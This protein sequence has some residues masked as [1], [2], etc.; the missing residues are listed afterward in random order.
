[1]P[2]FRSAALA[3]S[4]LAVVLPLT[5]CGSSD[6]DTGSAAPKPSGTVS[7]AAQS[8]DLSSVTLRVGQTG[9]AQLPAVLKVAGLDNTPYKVKWSV[10]PGGDKQ[11]QALQAGALDVASSSDI[12]PVFAAAATTPKWKVVGIQR[13]NTLLQNVV[14]GKKSGI[15]TIAQLKGKKVGYVQATTA[16]YFLYKLL[17]AAGLKWTDIHAVPLTP[18]D[19]VAA[20]SSGSIDAL[21]SYGNSIITTQQQGA[22]VIGSGQDILSGN[23]PYE[24]SDQL[25]ADADR[26]AALVDL[27]ARVNKAFTVLRDGHEAD[28]AELTAAATHEPESVA[29]AQI[30][31]DEQQIPSE[32][33]VGGP[34]Q[35]AKEQDVADTFS[36]LGIL[37][38]TVD[39]SSY[40]SDALTARL[41]TALAGS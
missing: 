25:I 11:I 26:S 19:G 36:Q 21:A 22:K 4:L 28:Y 29:L 35:I 5:A 2:R 27:L 34:D 40:W 41:T 15:T 33:Q 3:G 8:A 1:M 7:A 17:Q 10:F 18:Q 31:A 30:Q 39:V 38:G 9:W 14:A 23:F 16:H 20:L 6:S 24:A 32:V 37:P 13:T 12:P